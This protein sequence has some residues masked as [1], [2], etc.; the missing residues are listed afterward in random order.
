MWRN[1]QVT[2]FQTAS[3][4]LA[5]IHLH[6]IEVGGAN[7]INAQF[8]SMQC[9]CPFCLKP[10][11][12]CGINGHAHAHFADLRVK[13]GKSWTSWWCLT[14]TFSDW[15]WSNFPKF[16]SYSHRCDDRDGSS[17]PQLW[18][19]A[20]RRLNKVTFYSGGVH[21][22]RIFLLFLWQRNRFCPKNH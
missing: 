10:G 22:R 12:F 4:Q 3:K 15:F 5:L 16:S 20:A 6:L 1:W 13:I 19:C 9:P 2:P 7:P 18:A 17:V 21:R 14:Q 8:P 11:T